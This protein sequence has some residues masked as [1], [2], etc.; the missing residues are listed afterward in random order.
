M[1]R[2]KSNFLLPDCPEI[3]GAYKEALVLQRKSLHM[4]VEA[5]A[6]QVIPSFLTPQIRHAKKLPFRGR[7]GKRSQHFNRAN[8]MDHRSI[9][10][11]VYIVY[12]Y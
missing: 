6:S 4:V 8:H 1:K 3:S 11:V 9:H 2:S 12:I 7:M 10:T 5:I